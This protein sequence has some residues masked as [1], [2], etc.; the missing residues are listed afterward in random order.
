MPVNPP[1]CQTDV[2]Y[3]P[4]VFANK[5]PVAL[6][7]PPAGAFNDG[8]PAAGDSGGTTIYSASDAGETAHN[9]YLQSWQNGSSDFD[10]PDDASLG[11]TSPGSGGVSPTTPTGDTSTTPTTGTVTTPPQSPTP[12]SGDNGNPKYIKYSDLP[13][14][15]AY[16]PPGSQIYSLQ[17]SKYFYLRDIKWAPVSWGGITAKQIA[18]NF[19]LLAQNVLDP[20]RERYNF[21]ISS[22]FRSPARNSQTAGASKSSE[23]MYGKAGDC[24]QGGNKKQA[25]ELFAYAAKSGLPIRQLIFEGRWVHVSYSRGEK[26]NIL[27]LPNA[28]SKSGMQ[29]FSWSNPDAA[30][31]AARQYV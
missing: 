26:K 31:S 16:P 3:S 17:I 27:L 19:V 20:M 5:V 21:T 15:Q 7:R 23:H 25:F 24:W 14:A 28:P 6:W 2:Y 8:T 29:S 12:A 11:G 9:R 13:D 18:W 4:N 22:G 30:I 10:D 1:S